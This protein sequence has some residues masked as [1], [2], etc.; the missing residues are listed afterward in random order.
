MDIWKDMQFI[1]AGEGDFLPITQFYRDVIEKTPD[2]Q[3]YARWIYGKHPTDD[4]IRRYLQEGILYY[5]QHHGAILSAV[6]ISCSQGSDY[7]D[8]DWALALPDDAVAVVHLLGV[9]PQWQH[10]GIAAKTMGF[11]LELARSMGKKA[12][13]LDALASNTPAHGLYESLGF[14]RRGTAH[15]QTEN[16]GWADFYLFER[17]L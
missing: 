9:N 12:V 4:M 6:A 1:K 13:R 2:M 17:I 14:Q 11:V 15:W 10:H 7:Q 8:G 3:R 5:G 16:V